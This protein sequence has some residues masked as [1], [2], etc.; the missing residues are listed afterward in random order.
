V[1]TVGYTGSQLIQCDRRGIY[2]IEEVTG[3]SATD[4][5]FKEVT[6]QIYDTSK[7][8][9][10]TSISSSGT[11][12][13]SSSESK[14]TASTVLYMHINSTDDYVTKNYVGTGTYV[15]TL[16]T[17]FTYIPAVYT[18]DETNLTDLAYHTVGFTNTPSKYAY[19]SS[20]AY[21]VNKFAFQEAVGSSGN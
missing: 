6:A 21:A 7:L 8:Y 17:G 13:A 15:K 20:Q 19:L 9:E 11:T 16:P 14:V 2:V 10:N 18:Y 4:Y 5:D 1:T 12:E 3:L